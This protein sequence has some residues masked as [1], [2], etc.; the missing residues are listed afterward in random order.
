MIGICANTSMLSE[1]DAKNFI[2]EISKQTGL[3]VTDPIRYGISDIS[4]YLLEN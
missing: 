3:K 2:I 4:T 1:E